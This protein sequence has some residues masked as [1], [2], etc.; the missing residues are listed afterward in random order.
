ML[1]LTTTRRLRA[2]EKQ[3][4]RAYLSAELE[5]CR[6]ERARARERKNLR[7]RLDRVLRALAA[8]RRRHATSDGALLLVSHRLIDQMPDPATP[9]KGVAL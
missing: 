4:A 6:L 9:A 1:G 5:R 8:E 2:V 7:G 3:L